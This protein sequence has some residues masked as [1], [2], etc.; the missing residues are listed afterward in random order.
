MFRKCILIRET[1]FTLPNPL[2]HLFCRLV[3]IVLKGVLEEGS[4]LTLI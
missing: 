4:G 3:N 1:L 2:A